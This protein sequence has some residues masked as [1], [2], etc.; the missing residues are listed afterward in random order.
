[1]GDRVLNGLRGSL[2]ITGTVLLGGC[3]LVLI[4]SMV[5]QAS[6]AHRLAAYG[7]WGEQA[8]R[9]A[10]ARTNRLEAERSGLV[11]RIEI[12]R[13]KLSAMVLE[14]VSG[15]ALQRGV[16]RVPGTAFPGEPGN[17]GLAGHRDTYF[18]RLSDVRPG[19][20]IRLVTPGGAFTYE[21]ESLLVVDPARVDVLAKG[22]ANL[23]L[24]T[25]FPFAW[26]GPAPRRFVVLARETDGKSRDRAAEVRHEDRF[27][28]T[29]RGIDVSASA[30]GRP[31]PAE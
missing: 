28:G 2:I 31:G 23:T 7:P 21:A 12:P 22:R 4:D 8:T 9:A 3:L 30:P 10:I 5:F 6:L 16:G 25:C 19:D 14:G 26:V 11:G 1:M 27:G 18:R 13:I 29:R 15:H 17:I 24:V 20:H